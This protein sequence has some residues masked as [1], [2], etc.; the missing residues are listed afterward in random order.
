M[1]ES[2]ITKSNKIKIIVITALIFLVSIAGISYA[3]FTI[4][5]IGNDTA[6][7]MRLRTANMSLVYNDV[8]IVSGEYVEPGWTQTKTL[9]VTNNGNVNADYIIKFRELVNTIINGE[10]VISATCTS[11]TGTCDNLPERA[12]HS[13][14]TEITDAYMYGPIAIAPGVTHTYTLTAEFKETGS[15]QNYNQN[16][17][18]N[19][20]LNIGDG[21][22]TSEDLFTYTVSNDEVTITGYKIGKNSTF[23]IVDVNACQ[24]TGAYMLQQSPYNMDSSSAVA[25]A[26]VL[27]SGGTIQ[28][29]TIEDQ[30]YSGAI[31][32]EYYNALGIIVDIS[33]TVYSPSDVIIPSII[34]GKQV[35]T[36]DEYAFNGK[37]LTSVVIPNSVEEIERDAFG[38]NLLTSVIIPNSITTIG[39]NVFMNNQ[40]TSIVIPNSVTSLGWSSFDSNQL[41]SAVI[42]NGITAIDETMFA[43]NQLTTIIIPNGITGLG[44][45]S[46]SGN[47]LTKVI[48]PNTVLYINGGTFYNNQLSTVTIPSSVEYIYDHSFDDN[49]LTSVIIEGKSDSNDFS[50]YGYGNNIWGWASGSGCTDAT[51][52]T[53]LGS[54][55]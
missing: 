34:D 14:S 49:Q 43:N 50:E 31:E 26:Q 45:Y 2:K 16:K 28:G 9:T 7:S 1:E 11:S 21:T 38:S 20:T 39:K 33:K 27:C 18:F 19:G 24:S 51:C 35:T 8:Q 5:I 30:V 23:E 13:A 15:N 6:S 46:F 17:Y 12:V 36:T 40:L 29:T 22:A 10:L 41:I 44:Y 48:I 32:S 54:G 3:Y 52:I 55:S 42:S 47:R 4:Q 37:N 53:W 25:A